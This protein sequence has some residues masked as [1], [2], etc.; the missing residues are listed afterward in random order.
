MWWG[1]VRTDPRALERSR[2]RTSSPQ[3]GTVN[4]IGRMEPDITETVP[5]NADIAEVRCGQSLMS[6]YQL[7][8]ETHKGELVIGSSKHVVWGALEL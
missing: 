1:W 8:I 3:S 2:F 6:Y 5:I 7:L 4:V